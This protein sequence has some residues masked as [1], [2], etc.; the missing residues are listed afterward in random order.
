MKKMKTTSKPK[1]TIDKIERFLKK[2][3]KL[4]K[5]GDGTV[6]ADK[7]RPHILAQV[8]NRIAE[9]L[10]PLLVN[11]DIKTEKIPET[12]GDPA[13]ERK[14]AKFDLNRL[15]K[16]IELFKETDNSVVITLGTEKP[17]EIIGLDSKT[18]ITLAPMK[19]DKKRYNKL[20][21]KI[22]RKNTT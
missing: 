13:W 2:W 9:I 7:K 20:K 15:R 17:M 21:E 12:V 6:W 19:S 4:F 16:I 10:T 5:L 22:E 11:K 3:K 18:K 1:E 8:N 14:Y